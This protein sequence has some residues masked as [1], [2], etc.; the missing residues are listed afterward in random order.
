MDP[1]THVAA[2]RRTLVAAGIVLAILLLSRGTAGVGAQAPDPCAPPNGNPV[3]CENQQTGAPSSEWDIIVAP[4]T[5]T[6]Q[7]FATDISVN[8]GETIDFKIDTDATSYQLDIY[9]MGY[10]GGFGAR[11]VATVTPSATLPQVQPACLSDA[12]TGLVD[13][14]NWAVSASWAVPSTAVSGIYFAKVTRI[15]TGGAS[16][17]VFVVRDDTGHSDL[18]FQTSDTTWQAYNQYGGNSLYVGSPGR[19]APTRSATT[20]PSRRADGAGGLGLQRRVPDGPVARGERLQRQLLHRR[21]LRPPRRRAAG[22]QGSCPSATTSTGRAASAPT[23][24]RRARPASTSRSSAAT[25]SSGRPGGRTSISTRPRRLT[26]RWS[27]TRRRTPTR[28]SIR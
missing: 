4:A 2:F 17:I 28:R 18:L 6:I 16:H 13:C 26:A 15:D 8:R 5:P 7:G 14:G 12:T 21:R 3:V 24:K 1:L 10:Y 19:A 23:S 25:K 9:R 11:K 27:A 22:A 20:G